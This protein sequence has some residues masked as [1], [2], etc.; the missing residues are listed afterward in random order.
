MKREK[1]F[2]RDAK[3][4][5]K[6]KNQSYASDL[7]ISLH[8]PQGGL[9]GKPPQETCF[10]ACQT[11]LISLSHKTDFHSAQLLFRKLISDNAFMR[12]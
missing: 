9:R 5:H 1:N 12:F 4:S 11:H 3:H 2:I 7:K 6:T 10:L 8:G